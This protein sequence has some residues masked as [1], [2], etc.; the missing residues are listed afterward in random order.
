MNERLKNLFS[1]DKKTSNLVLIVILLVMVLIASNV[2]FDTDS[3]G[4][5]KSKQ[6]ISENIT[7]TKITSLEEKLANIISKI[8]GVDKVD[9]MVTYSTTEKIIPVYDTRVD[10][11]VTSDGTKQTTEKNVAY[12]SEGNSKVAIVESKE[13]AEA[14]G[15]IVVAKGKVSDSVKSEIKSAVSMVTNVP[16]HKIQIFINN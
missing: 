15:A 5:I 12:E 1:K 16:I 2:I 14:I 4:N 6:T 3:S 10:T 7:E 13:S 8:D 11:N 9:V